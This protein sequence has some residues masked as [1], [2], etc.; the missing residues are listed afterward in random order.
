MSQP[1][2]LDRRALL[3][4][5]AG[6]MPLMARAGVATGGTGRNS[7]FSAVL[8]SVKPV[9]AGGVA[10]DVSA[11]QLSDGEGRVLRRSDLDTGM[12]ARVL[13]GPVVAGVAQAQTLRVDT[14]L[15]GPASVLDSRHLQ[16]LGQVVSL[17]ANVTVPPGERLRVW[18]QLD[19]AGGR[20]VAT[21]IQRAGHDDP[22]MLRGL[23]QSLDRAAGTAMV[24][25]LPLR[26]TGPVADDLAPGALVRASLAGP[27]VAAS[28][29]D[30]AVRPPDGTLV[31]LEGRITSLQSSR[32]FLL[33][34][35]AVEASKAQISGS[36]LQP[37]ASVSAEG[38][39]VAG[40]LVATQVEVEPAEPVELAGRVTALDL[41]HQRLVVGGRSVR[42]TA[43]TVFRQG[44]ARA[45]KLGRSVEILAEWRPAEADLIALRIALA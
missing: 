19:L 26:L 25:G 7:F 31:E 29:R 10:L 37:G 17:G 33:D 2:T 38:R 41:S 1:K 43:A 9:T 32:R 36:P 20:V 44:S 24:N 22:D 18:G 23:L 11:A 45:L 5:L 4:A 6:S 16:V 14:Q 15:A 40:V 8:T 3:A 12:T 30:D 35:L 28:L 21:L 39:M 34:G 42:W 27:G 13:A